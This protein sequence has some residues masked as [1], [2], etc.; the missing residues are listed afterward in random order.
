VKKWLLKPPLYGEFLRLLMAWRVWVAGAIVGAVVAALIYVLTPP[1][2]R[3]QATVLVDQNVEQAIPYEHDE[4]SINTYLQRETDK[5]VELAWSDQVL[6]QLSTDTGISVSGL[7]DGRLY[8]SQPSDGGWHFI[9]DA[10]DSETAAEIASAW[11]DSFVK[12]IQ[13]KP[14]GISTFLEINFTQQQDLSVE[15]AASAGVYAFSGA[16]LG[17]IL[18]AF[19]L[20]FFDRK[21]A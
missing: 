18:L 20:L 9:V 17:A 10:P 6:S 5:L 14:T 15:R 1:Q 3:A 16:L 2:Y 7:R 11:A 21:E 12:A 8:L 4:L 19:G 13:A